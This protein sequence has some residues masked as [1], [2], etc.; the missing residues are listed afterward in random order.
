MHTLTVQQQV[1]LVSLI[2]EEFGSHLEFEDFAEA[3]LG[4]FENIP[5]FETISHTQSTC[6]VN[7]LWRKYR[8]QEICEEH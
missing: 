8:G 7:Q 4:L 5:G 1:E 2:N 3:M 6:V